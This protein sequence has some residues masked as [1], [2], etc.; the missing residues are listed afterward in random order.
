MK[1]L[2]HR[3]H[4]NF[5]LFNGNDYFMSEAVRS[6]IA[7]HSMDRLTALAYVNHMGTVRAKKVT[8]AGSAS[9][10]WIGIN[11]VRDPLYLERSPQSTLVTEEWAS[12]WPATAATQGRGQKQ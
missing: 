2:S 10:S 12:H 4:N 9:D 7:R 1:T 8:A 5:S 11:M 6:D 3:K